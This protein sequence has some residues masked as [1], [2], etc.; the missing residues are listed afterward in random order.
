MFRAELWCGNNLL[1]GNVAIRPRHRPLSHSLDEYRRKR[2]VVILIESR[3]SIMHR[4]PTLY[5]IGLCFAL[6]QGAHAQT[7]YRNAV[8]AEVGGNAYYY[9]LNFERKLP[10]QF[11]ARIGIGTVPE[12]LIVPALTGKLFGK[13]SHML[14]AMAGLAYVYLRHQVE[15]VDNRHQLVGTA[16]MGYRFEKRE[17]RLLF[18]AGWTPH[19]RIHDTYS[20]FKN[21]SFSH[22]MGIA[23]GYR[24]K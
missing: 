6:Y 17:G 4:I 5:C 12:T 13:G 18:R 15:G 9:S 19:L 2:L 10:R 3:P 20:P 22:W 11:A 8:Y 7:D 24:F 14:E 23:F 21:N 1:V 16:F